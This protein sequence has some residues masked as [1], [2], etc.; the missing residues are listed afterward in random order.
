[1]QSSK[2]NR[3]P[4][5]LC[6]TLFKCLV[7]GLLWTV[8]WGCASLPQ[9]P[10]A[11]TSETGRLTAQELMQGFVQ[12]KGGVYFDT[13]LADYIQQLG[14]KLGKK[15]QRPDLP[16]NFVVV[17][18]TSSE[19]HLFPQG[20]ILLTRGLIADMKNERDLAI[21]LALAIAETA[22]APSARQ[23]Q[24]NIRELRAMRPALPETG[25]ATPVPELFEE[26]LQKLH[27]ARHG[28]LLFDEAQRL[29]R[30]GNVSGAI[31]TY[32]QAATAAPDQ[33]QILTGLGLAYLLAGDLQSARVHLQRS[34]RLQ[35]AHYLSRMG[36]GYIELQRERYADAVVELEKSVELL[37]IM[38]NR[39]LLA[40]GYE[41][42]GQPEAAISLYRA[43]T[44]KDGRSKLG[45]E[46]TRRLQ[47]LEN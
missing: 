2:M 9:M 40:E 44:R 33:P 36:Q 3:I 21:L 24:L 17:D 45:R 14:R 39:F 38:R 31:S 20:Q 1:M 7:L 5:Q 46:A 10:P 35:P 22:E 25:H 29:E 18:R 41:K 32:L 15:S 13:D 27:E 19:L 28:Y 30:S 23:R 4:Q 43:V 16:Y 37:P 6:G 12:E 8:L 11:R 34:I 42:N 47:Q 26:M